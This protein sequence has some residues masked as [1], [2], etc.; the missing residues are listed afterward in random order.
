MPFSPT[1]SIF[2]FIFPQLTPSCI[3]KFTVD[4]ELV[5][6]IEAVVVEDTRSDPVAME[7]FGVATAKANVDNVQELVDKLKKAEE[8]VALHLILKGV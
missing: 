3:N 2:S 5:I 8:R 6:T 7:S 4:Q 1:Y